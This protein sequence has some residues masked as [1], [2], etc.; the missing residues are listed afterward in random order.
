MLNK[1][2]YNQTI[3]VLVYFCLIWAWSST[4]GSKS[5]RH[6]ILNKKYTEFC[7]LLPTDVSNSW[8]RGL[9]QAN[10]T[11]NFSTSTCQPVDDA[12]EN[13]LSVHNIP[14]NGFPM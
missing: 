2:K 9:D 4:G 11:V 10:D 8:Q 14:F 6:H 3:F 12:N 13:T 7:M 5:S 1:T